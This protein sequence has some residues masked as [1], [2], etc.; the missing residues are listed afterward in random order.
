[1]HTHTY[2][3]TLYILVRPV[4]HSISYKFHFYLPDIHGFNGS[5]VEKN[6]KIA[7]QEKC[8][9]LSE[10]NILIANKNPKFGFKKPVAQM[11]N[12]NSS[13]RD[14]HYVRTQ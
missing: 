6:L 3:H 12:K 7:G 10:W 8:L 13:P 14:Q 5:I 1:M 2:T 11:C 9:N 4:S